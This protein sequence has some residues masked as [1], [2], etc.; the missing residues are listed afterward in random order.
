MTRDRIDISGEVL[1]VFVENDSPWIRQQLFG[2]RPSRKKIA[3]SSV[4][5]QKILAQNEGNRAAS[6]LRV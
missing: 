5:F 6:D 4:M 3:R 1:R 2:I